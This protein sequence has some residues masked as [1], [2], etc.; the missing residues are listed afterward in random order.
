MAVNL[1]Q[2]LRERSACDV[3]RRILR[4]DGELRHVRWVG[5][6]VFDGEPSTASSGP[7]WM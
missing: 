1:E 2:M 5:V 4:P 6:P 7:Q 3:T